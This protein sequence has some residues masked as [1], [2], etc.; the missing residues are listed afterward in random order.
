MKKLKKGTALSVPF[1]MEEINL[2]FLPVDNL[3]L[4]FVFY[5]IK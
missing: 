3:H 5:N 2:Y 4:K 1:L